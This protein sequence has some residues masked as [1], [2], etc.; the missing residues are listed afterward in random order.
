MSWNNMNT[1]F[2]SLRHNWF[3]NEMCHR[4]DE[5]ANIKIIG[6]NRY[7]EA[8]T[9]DNIEDATVFD[10]ITEDTANSDCVTS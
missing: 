10:V 4:T 3:C 9:I 1:G 5:I 2:R 7:L 8:R 6:H